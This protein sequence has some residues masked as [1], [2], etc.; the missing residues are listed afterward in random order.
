VIDKIVR[1]TRITFEADRPLCELESIGP[2]AAYGGIGIIGASLY[3][4]GWKWDN[5]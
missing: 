1:A 3:L 2:R 5:C 4:D